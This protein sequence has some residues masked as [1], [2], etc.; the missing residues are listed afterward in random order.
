[1]KK[2]WIDPSI[3]SLGLKDTYDLSPYGSNSGNGNDGGVRPDGCFCAD[4]GNNHDHG[5]QDKKCT[6]CA[7]SS[8]TVP[9]VS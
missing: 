7:G 3:L 4:S 5:A 2:E 9:E 1:M 8:G 6:C